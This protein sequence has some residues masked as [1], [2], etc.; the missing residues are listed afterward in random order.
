MGVLQ[1]L[2]ICVITLTG[3]FQSEAQTVPKLVLGA[4]PTPEITLAQ[5][6][7]ADVPGFS[8]VLEMS[9]SLRD[10]QSIG[11][12]LSNQSERP[13]IG[14]GVQWTIVDSV[15]QKRTL[16][17]KSHSFIAPDFAPLAAPHQRLLV[18]PNMFIQEPVLRNTGLIVFSPGRRTAILF[19]AASEVHI[20]IDSIIFGDGEV[21]GP[22][23]LRLPAEIQARKD[24]ADM[25]VRHVHTSAAVFLQG[26]DQAYADAATFKHRVHE[27]VKQLDGQLPPEHPVAAA[28]K[29][30]RAP[31]Q[32]DPVGRHSVE[33]AEDLLRTQHFRGV[34]DYIESIPAPPVFYRK[35]GQR[36]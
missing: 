26:N 34:F 12:I 25:I 31:S 35:D 30:L 7:G 15:G 18:M 21:I 1:K 6:A 14:I 27:F 23:A 33:F 22:N 32:N 36:L 5:F 17:Y 8:R 16:A 11:F 19:G 24:A 28:L 13:I 4:S 10:L 20:E 9:P 29:Q 2:L 3:I